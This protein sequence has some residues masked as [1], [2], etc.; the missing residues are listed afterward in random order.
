MS[1]EVQDI[2]VEEVVTIDEEAT[3]KEAV[4]LMNKHE[5]GC[6]IAM[7]K[8]KPSGILTERDLLRRVLV[9]SKDSEK[10]KVLEVMSKPIVV[11]KPKMEV[12]EAVRLMFKM[13]IKKLPVVEKGRLLGLITLTDLVRFQPQMISILKKLSVKEL[14]PKRMKKV[15]DYYIA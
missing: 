2:M 10:I 15:V 6:L 7:K 4:K 14:T 12:E 9:E 13:K 3:V 8:G 11:G 1:L 5:I